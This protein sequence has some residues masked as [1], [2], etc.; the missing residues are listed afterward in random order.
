MT[1]VTLEDLIQRP[2]EVLSE[3]TDAIEGRALSSSLKIQAYLIAALY[4]LVVI[5]GG[6]GCWNGFRDGRLLT[7]V[8]SDAVCMQVFQVIYSLGWICEIFFVVLPIQ[9]DL[10]R[11]G[12]IAFQYVVFLPLS[13]TARWQG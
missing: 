9:K 3:L 6:I 5:C 2:L 7:R 10:G 1:V 8:A 4:G 12:I 11:Y 13:V